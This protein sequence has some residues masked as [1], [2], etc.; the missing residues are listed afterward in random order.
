MNRITFLLIIIFSLFAFQ[1]SAQSGKGKAGE[2]NP[3]VDQGLLSFDSNSMEGE[4]SFVYDESPIGL[5]L[6]PTKTLKITICMMN[7]VPTN[8]IESVGGEISKKFKWQFSQELN[9]L[10]GVQIADFKANDSGRITVGVK[11][12]DANVIRDQNNIGFVANIQPSPLMNETN[13]TE[14]DAV[15]VY[16]R[17]DLVVSG[18]T[19]KGEVEEKKSTVDYPGFLKK[20]AGE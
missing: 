10:R 9:C 13:D 5:K 19:V 3:S 17:A 4:F 18:Q 1:M 20:R 6:N 12:K 16:K 15:A 11:A 7:V 8:G 14:D 2:L